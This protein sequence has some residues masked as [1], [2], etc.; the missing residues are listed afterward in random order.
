MKRLIVAMVLLG[1]TPA[2]AQEVSVKL[3]TVTNAWAFGVMRSLVG[4]AATCD[5]QCAL[6]AAAMMQAMANAQ[7]VKPESDKKPD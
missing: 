5:P 7:P 6:Q 2:M 3:P 1:A 4:N